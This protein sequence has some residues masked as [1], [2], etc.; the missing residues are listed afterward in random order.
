MRCFFERER[1]AG[2][3]EENVSKV[4]VSAETTQAAMR[5]WPAVEV[6]LHGTSRRWVATS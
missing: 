3:S 4:C 6:K 5:M 1:G 2:D